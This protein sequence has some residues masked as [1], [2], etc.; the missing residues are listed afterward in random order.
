[1]NHEPNK[2]HYQT[3]DRQ[4]IWHPYTRFS[5]LKAESLPIITHGGGAYLY[6]VDGRKYLDAISSW[7]ACN[8]GHGHPAIVDAII[9]Q[10]RELQHSILGN[11]S[12]PRAI[13][14]ASMIVGLFPDDRRVMIASDGA[15]AGEA[16]LKIAMQY[17]YNIGLVHKTKFI[18]L[19]LAYHGDNRCAV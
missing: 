8:L 17:W 15:C 11:L 18:S 19:D 7:W 5:A 2:Q 6:D 10:T 13:E 4:S 14:L 3:L 16:A 1:M 9:R 12:H